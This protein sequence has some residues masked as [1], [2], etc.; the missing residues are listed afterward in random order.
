MFLAYHTKTFLEQRLQLGGLGRS[1]LRAMVD[2]IPSVLRLRPPAIRDVPALIEACS[3]K[4]ISRWTNVPRPYQEA[5]AINFVNSSNLKASTGQELHLVVTD[6]QDV[7]IGACGLVTIDWPNLAAELG[8]WTTPSS[9]GQGI[10]TQAARTLAFFALEEL[11][12]ERI[13]IRAASTNEASHRVAEKAGFQEEGRLR[14]AI[15]EGHTGLPGQPRHDVL[16]FGLIG[17]DLAPHGTSALD[18]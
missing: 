5:D 14:A 8:Y 7:L 18:G 16:V 11:G 2:R 10:A 12:L 4:E 3:D 6:E 9:R 17:A 1:A 15:S 13:T